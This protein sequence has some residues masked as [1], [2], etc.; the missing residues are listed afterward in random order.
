VRS[1]HPLAVGAAALVTSLL[2]GGCFTGDRPS[3]VEASNEPTGDAA[4]DAVVELLESPESGAFT[5]TYEITGKYDNAKFPATVTRDDT[6]LS[7][8]IGDVRYLST[9]AGTQ[10]CTVSTG[11]CTNGFDDAKI[12]NTGVLH[13]FAK[14]SAAA[15]LRREAATRTGPAESA[16]ATVGEQQ[17][18]CVRLS[19][20]GGTT[21]FCALPS[22]WL[23][24][25][26]VAEV[27]ITLQSLTPAAT[28]AL[29]TPSGT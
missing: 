26:D 9:E 3:F 8:T 28:E 25:E 15:R 13:T 5:A 11:A 24:L 23:A 2:L 22:G 29:F 17:V 7:I 1:R 4:V 18:D 16:P 12:S 14:E 6:R 10:T 21:Q 27:N 20:A 19:G